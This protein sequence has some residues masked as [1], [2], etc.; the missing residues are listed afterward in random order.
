MND[1]HRKLLALTKSRRA[2]TSASVN[3]IMEA[4]HTAVVATEMIETIYDACSHAENNDVALNPQSLRKWIEDHR[5]Q[6]NLATAQQ[7]ISN[8]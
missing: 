3:H 6:L 4:A 5:S 1:Q 7:E 8:D 2:A